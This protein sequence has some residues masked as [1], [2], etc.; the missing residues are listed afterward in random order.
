MMVAA[1]IERTELDWERSVIATAVTQ[2]A[3]IEEAADL[4]PADFTGANQIAWAEV[5]ALHSREGLDTRALINAL[6]SSP[7]WER[8]SAGVRVEDYL[9]E[10]LS[11]RGTNMHG[12]VEMVLDR[13]IKRALRRHMALIAAEAEDDTKTA[14]EILDFAEQKILSLRRNR[15]D[16]GYTIQDLIGIFVPRM[17][18]QL[19]GTVEPAWVPAVQGVKN[20]IDYMEAEDFMTVAARPG[21]GKSSY[22]RFEFYKA[23]KRGRSVG[24][25]NYENAPIEYLRYFL[26]IE[27]GIDTHKLKNPRLLTPRRRKTFAWG[28]TTSPACGSKSRIPSAPQTT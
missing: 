16:E 20:V 14:Q 18:A 8:M 21:E 25:L 19:D 10:V 17:Q 26:G 9:A 2:P 4:L 11:F 3:S 5:L 1:N 23:A 22:M 27:T 15:M 12:Y 7:D 6:R 24:I 13:S 28:S